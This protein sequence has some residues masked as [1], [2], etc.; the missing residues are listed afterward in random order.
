MRD[1]SW[2]HKETPLPSTAI[3]PEKMCSWVHS[4]KEIIHRMTDQSLCTK[5]I[6]NILLSSIQKHSLKSFFT[7]EWDWNAD[8]GSIS[9]TNRLGLHVAFSCLR[10]HSY[11][12]TNE[13]GK[14]LFT[15][16]VFLII[17]PRKCG[18]T[19]PSRWSNSLVTLTRAKKQLSTLFCKT[20]IKHFGHS[21]CPTINVT[22]GSSMTHGGYTTT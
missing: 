1:K 5:K 9:S 17:V 21:F 7:K 15:A 6:E 10:D 14:L 18:H 20:R 4:H 12:S 8:T 16:K 13:T 19:G 2:N 3:W 11:D 22:S